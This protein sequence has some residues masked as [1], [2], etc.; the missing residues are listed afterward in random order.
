MSLLIHK[1][2]GLV[3]ALF[4]ILNCQGNDDLESRNASDPF[5]DAIEKTKK[6]TSQNK[7]TI[8]I[9]NGTGVKNLALDIGTY[10]RENCYDIYIDYKFRKTN[11]SNTFIEVNKKKSAIAEELKKKLGGNIEVQYKEPAIWDMTLV[12]GKDYEKLTYEIE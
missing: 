12:I 6:C 11:V 4:L 8:D 1:N 9:K 2:K 7:P 10:L 5:N 3:L